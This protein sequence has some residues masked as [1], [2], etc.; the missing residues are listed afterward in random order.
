MKLKKYISIF[1][2]ILWALGM[3]IGGG[4]L[5]YCPEVFLTVG[6]FGLVPAIIGPTK[7]KRIIGIA[8]L[9]ISLFFAWDHY[10]GKEKQKKD[11]EEI[12]K[13]NEEYI[14]DK[15]FSK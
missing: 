13:A 1:F 11:L 14:L 8:A 7:L 12:K 3:L 4:M 9:C 5:C 2:I 10:E 15:K 6:A